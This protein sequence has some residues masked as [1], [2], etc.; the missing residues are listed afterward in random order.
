MV[1]KYDFNIRICGFA[2]LAFVAAYVQTLTGFA[3]GL[4]LMGSVAVS[5][6][7]PLPEAAIVI[8]L[9]T[10]TNAGMVLARGWRDIAAKPFCCRLSALYR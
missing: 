1:A 5:G 3:F 6:L 8:S 9:L 7:V 10:L 2:L 4:L